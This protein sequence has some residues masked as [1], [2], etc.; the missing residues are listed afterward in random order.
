[1]L[2]MCT[3]V[4]YICVSMHIC[5][6]REAELKPLCI[7]PRLPMRDAHVQPL[8]QAAWAQEPIYMYTHTWG[9]KTPPKNTVLFEEPG[10]R[11]GHMLN[12]GISTREPGFVN[13]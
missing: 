6:A 11:K 1:M 12:P 13:L 9:T 2:L 3:Y 4:Q 7:L 10:F 8:G 5:R